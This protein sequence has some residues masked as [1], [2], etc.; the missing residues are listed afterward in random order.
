MHQ[1]CRVLIGTKRRTVRVSFVLRDRASTDILEFLLY[2]RCESLRLL[3]L[4]ALLLLIIEDAEGFRS[5]FNRSVAK[6]L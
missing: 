3:C 6:V 5:A 1:S 4:E 2:S